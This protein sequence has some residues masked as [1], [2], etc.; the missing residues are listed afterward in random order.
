[1]SYSSQKLVLLDDNGSFLLWRSADEDGEEVTTFWSNHQFLSYA[2]IRGW[3]VSAAVEPK[4]QYYIAAVQKG[5]TVRQIMWWDASKLGGG[6]RPAA[7]DEDA[8][9]EM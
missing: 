4:T 5:E 3:C 1:M 8:G 6:A 9:A 2:V 7:D